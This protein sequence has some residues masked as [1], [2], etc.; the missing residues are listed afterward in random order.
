[1]ITSI[2]C[3][4]RNLS[5][6]T[7]MSALVLAAGASGCSGPEVLEA[8]AETIDKTQQPLAIGALLSV[9]G[10]YEAGC[11]D[12]SGSWSIEIDPGATLDNPALSVI[13]NDTACQLTV[14]SLVADDEYFADPEITLA[15]SYQISASAFS[16]AG[17]APPVAFFANAKM[18][19]ADFS[20]NFAVTILYSDD[21]NAASAAN[22]ASYAEWIASALGDQVAAPDYATVDNMSVS[23]DADGMVTAASGSVNLTDGSVTGERYFVDLGTLPGSPSYEDVE[24]LFSGASSTAIAGADPSIG[25]ASFGLSGQTLPV[26]RTLIIRH[27]E[28]GV[29]SFQ[30]FKV[31]FNAP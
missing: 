11:T 1:M 23:T 22:N 27:M 24:A 12:R 2:R 26:V 28:S 25:V 20:A 18:N 19:P 16:V 21:Q 3:R 15:S 17:A 10:A 7:L 31:T 8:N 14:T 5:I 29:A 30:T 6:V 9:N 4:T 13:K